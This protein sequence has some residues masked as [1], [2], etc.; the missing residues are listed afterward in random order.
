M[1]TYP[2]IT[3]DSHFDPPLSLVEKLPVEHRDKVPRLE[4]REDGTYLVRPPFMARSRMGTMGGDDDKIGDVITQMLAAGVKV[5]DPT[6]ERAV[7]RAVGGNVCTEARPGFTIE[8]RL[9]EMERDGIAGELLISNGLFHLFDDADA[10]LLWCG[11]VNDWIVDTFKGHY[12]TFAPTITLP[13]SDV[14]NAARELER[15]AALGLRVGMLPYCIPGEFFSMPKWEPLWDAAEKHDIRLIFHTSGRPEF[16]PQSAMLPGVNLTVLQYLFAATTDVLGSLVN[17][18][19]FE[20]HPNLQVAMIETTAGW[21]EWFMD[22]ADFYHGYRYSTEKG[23]MH[24]PEGSIQ[25]DLAPPSYYI[26][27]NVKASFMWDQ[28]AIRNRHEIGMDC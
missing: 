3:T 13:L 7:A 22:S 17:S 12:D 19:V 27:K 15:C 21:L 6:D 28:V 4:E 25:L 14:D 20:R 26:K 2:L 5:D 11:I 16:G 10:D 18:G 8:S 1:K 9:E 24:N 23:T